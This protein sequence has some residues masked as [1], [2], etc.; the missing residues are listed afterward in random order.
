[1]EV[2][3][4][5]RLRITAGYTMR[6]AGAGVEVGAAVRVM[7]PRVAVARGVR[8]GVAVGVAVGA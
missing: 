3:E 4:A 7:V 6:T 5:G 1:M 2:P 8:V